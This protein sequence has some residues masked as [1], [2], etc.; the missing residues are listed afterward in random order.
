MPGAVAATPFLADREPHPGR[1]L[2]GAQ[3]IFMRRVFEVAALERDQALIA[4]HI[5]AL[6][7]GHR[8]MTLA[9]QLA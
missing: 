3:E 9:E 4:A 5:R 7:D 6:V 2:F 1:D 8:E